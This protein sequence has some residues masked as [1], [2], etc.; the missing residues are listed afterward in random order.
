MTATEPAASTAQ[1]VIVGAG[2]V[3]LMLACELGRAG[4]RPLVLERAVE[5]SAM[6]KG[7]G[8]VGEIAAVLK[9]RGLLR[10]EKGLH[11][12]P[13]PRYAFGPLPLRLNPFRADPLRVLPIPQRRLEELLE[14]HAREL[15]ATIRRGHA[16]AGCH[17]DGGRVR[18]NVTSQDGGYTVDAQFLAGCDGAHSFVRHH[19]GIAFPGL[20][21]DQLT[22]IGRVTI[23][24]GALR[25]T[26]NII[27][28]PGGRPVTLFQ[29]N[30]T[31]AGAITLA[32]VAALDRNTPEDLYIVATHEPRGD[33]APAGHI[34]MEEFQASIRRVLGVELPITDGQWLRSTVGNSRQAEQ[35]R[36]GRV[37][38]AGDAAHVFSAGGSSLNTGM[39]DAVDLAPRLAAVLSGAA[40]IE[41]L[42][43]YHT[44]RHA[45]G[46]QTLRQTRAQ[47][48][49]S[50]PGENADALRQVLGDAFR[51]RSPHRYLATQ[52]I[53]S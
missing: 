8:L 12:I 51:A 40:A 3:G 2:P 49:L 9:R 28:L 6:P 24:A 25:R 46:Q 29:P 34:C 47:A 31:A 15:G 22:R 43:D 13:L 21:S 19:L 7:N 48:A 42:E 39:L 5:P 35:Y 23:P 53:G 32:P 27:E 41:T 11:A 20:T 38:L 37:F 4:I 52:L 50:A 1:V 33:Q 36:A 17:D 18:V 10:G 16:V 45:A 44:V 14:R 26:R 30:H